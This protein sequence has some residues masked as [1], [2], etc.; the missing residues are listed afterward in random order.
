MSSTRF[1]RNLLPRSSR[2]LTLGVE[3]GQ[4][5]CPRR[6]VTDVEQC[7]ACTAFRG[8]QT[9]ASETIVCVPAVSTALAYVPAGF[10]P[11]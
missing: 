8:S 9:N 11:R 4:V 3:A 10:V 2:P 1:L 6:G 7:F 5:V